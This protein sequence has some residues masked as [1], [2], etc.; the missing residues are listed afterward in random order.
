MTPRRASPALR[1]RIAQAI[2]DL[3]GCGPVETF[4]DHDLVVCTH[5]R[6]FT[7]RERAPAD[8]ELITAVERCTQR[9]VAEFRDASEPD[10]RVAAQLFFL[11]PQVEPS[12]SPFNLPGESW[13]APR[14]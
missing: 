14:S 10:L 4:L 2:G 1:A 11:G 6:T 9:P 8:R 3:Y 12:P 13:T 7:R 5:Q